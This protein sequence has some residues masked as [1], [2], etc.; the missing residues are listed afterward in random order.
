MKP[1]ERVLNVVEKDGKRYREIL[2]AFPVDKDLRVLV[3]GWV[4]IGGARDSGAVQVRLDSGQ[5]V[6]MNSRDINEAVRLEE[7]MD[8]K[9]SEPGADTTSQLQDQPVK[10]A[11]TRSRAPKAPGAP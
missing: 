7:I 4:P 10:P 1:G 3:E 6:V 2:R 8:D 11:R 5:C 9:P